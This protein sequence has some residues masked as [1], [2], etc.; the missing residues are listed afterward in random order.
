MNK[1]KVG[2]EVVVVKDSNGISKIR[3]GED[4][5]WRIFTIHSFGSSQET[6]YP[7]ADTGAYVEDLELTAIVN[8]PLY[9]ALT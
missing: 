8:S 5:K 2:D 4:Y 7:V 3:N 9:E 1:F 6:A